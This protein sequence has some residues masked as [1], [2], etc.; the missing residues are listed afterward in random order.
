MVW[1]YD[2]VMPGPALRL[3]QGVPFH[4]IVENGL[5]EN[6]TVHWHG[7]RLPNAM[8]GVPGLTQPTIPPD[9]RFDYAFTPPDAG[10][11]W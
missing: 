4:A 11:F 2:G 9:G 7:I 8:D 6:T 1:A 5:D 10:T 3:R